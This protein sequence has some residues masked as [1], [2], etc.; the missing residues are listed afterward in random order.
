M[1]SL[2]RHRFGSIACSALPFM[3]ALSGCGHAVFGIAARQQRVLDAV[4]AQRA[5]IARRQA[6]PRPTVPA[7]DI[8][9][10]W[11]APP[12][13]GTEFVLLR[14][15]GAAPHLSYLVALD[16]RALAC[17]LDAP[18]DSVPLNELRAAPAIDWDYFNRLVHDEYPSLDRPETALALARLACILPAAADNP[19]VMGEAPTAPDAGAR[20]QAAAAAAYRQATPP[21]IEGTAVTGYTAHLWTAYRTREGAVAWTVHVSPAGVVRVSGIAVPGPALTADAIARLAAR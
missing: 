5:E 11:R 18:P 12:L 9:R 17:V 3:L 14:S 2:G 15:R 7:L 8:V 1:R 4:G 19:L 10:R 21:S 6:L 20:A 13:L 16:V